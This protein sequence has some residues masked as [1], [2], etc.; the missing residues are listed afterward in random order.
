MK[1]RYAVKKYSFTEL[2]KSALVCDR[3][4][5]T[6]KLVGEY[7]NALY[8]E[9]YL[10][11]L[12]IQT[13]VVEEDYVDSDYLT[14][15][16]AYYVRCHS[17][18]ERHTRRVHFF[19]TS[20]SPEEFDSLISGQNENLRNRLSVPV[21]KGAP[22]AYAG[23]MVIKPLP[24]TLIGRTCIDTYPVDDGAKERI[25]PIKRVYDTSLFGIALSIKSVAF[26]EQD[27]EVAACAPSALWS[28][29]HATSRIFGHSLPSPYEI[30]HQATQS[31]PDWFDS[32]PQTRRFPATGLSPAQ[33]AYAIRNAGLEPFLVG[34]QGKAATRAEVGDRTLVRNIVNAVAMAFLDAKIPFI[35]SV[36]LSEIIGTEKRLLGLHAMTVLGYALEK[37]RSPTQVSER[38]WRADR[39]K[40]LYV[41]DDQSGPFARYTWEGVG[42]VNN[43]T[44]QSKGS[45]KSKKLMAEPQCLIIPLSSKIRVDYADIEATVNRIDAIVKNYVITRAGPQNLHEWALR[46]Y[47]VNEL[48]AEIMDD[49]T[50]DGLQKKHIL[51]SALPKYIW[52]VTY[53]VED[54]SVA[55]RRDIEF[56]LDA[57]ALNQEAGLLECIVRDYPDPQRLKGDVTSRKND[58]LIMDAIFAVVNKEQV[59][60]NTPLWKAIVEYAQRLKSTQPMK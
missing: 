15:Y 51:S 23:F 49:Q 31:I 19:R 57:T 43:L 5:R 22:A 13:F 10:K 60:L 42:A 11:E 24:E 38:K 3:L 53:W 6:E 27:R 58:S 20:F 40:T 17:E 44:N 39:I 7:N 52:S 29:L 56:L 46:L 54:S 59:Q 21:D 30:T 32:Q 47:W 8:F 1:P 36:K 9:E 37:K 45:V 4:D 14:D 26:Q 48:K 16:A 12:N 28:L 33:I 18:Y 35:I 55:P 34:T 2:V 25:Y 50:I 41:H